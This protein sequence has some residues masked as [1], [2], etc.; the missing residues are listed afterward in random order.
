MAAFLSNFTI[1]FH[2]VISLYGWLWMGFFCS[3]EQWKK[4]QKRCCEILTMWIFGETMVWGKATFLSPL[5][6]CK[7]H[8]IYWLFSCAWIGLLQCH[9]S[10]YYW[11]DVFLLS[12]W[13]WHTLFFQEA[14]TRQSESF[15]SILFSLEGY[16][17]FALPTNPISIFWLFCCKKW[18]ES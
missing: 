16:T 14:H 9:Y 17:F 18:R 1:F 7:I 13:G 15:F 10:W 5:R 2:L 8:Q 4:D 6:F 12:S 3:P 11:Q